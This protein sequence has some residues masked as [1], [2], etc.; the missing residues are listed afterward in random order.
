M[1]CQ[2]PTL[3][4]DSACFQCLSESE[5]MLAQIALLRRWAAVVAPGADLSPS[6]LVQAGRA[7]SGLDENGMR[8]A[9]VGLLCRISGL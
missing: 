2:I 5:A 1:N 8:L 9:S 6:A 4:A 7:F 3:L